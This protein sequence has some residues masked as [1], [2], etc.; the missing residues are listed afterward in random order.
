MSELLYHGPCDDCGSSDACATYDD[1]HSYCFS[2]GSH[3]QGDAAMPEHIQ[4]HTKRKSL[5]IITPCVP[6]AS[7]NSRNL[8]PETVRRF[9]VGY[10]IDKE[11]PPSLVFPYFDE[12]GNLVAQKLRDQDKNFSTRGNLKQA[13]L[14]GAHLCG[15]GGRLVVVTEGELDAMAVDQ[16]M[17]SPNGRRYGAVSI[18]NGAQGAKKSIT[19][20]LDWLCS[21]ETVVLCFDMDEPGRAA[22]ED[23]VGLFPPGKAAVAQ[24]PLKDACEMVMAHRESELSSAIWNATPHVPGGIV[25]LADIVD[26]VR[27]A[28]VRGI[29]WCIPEIDDKLYGR[30]YG[31][32]VG[33]GA[34]TGVGKTTLMTQQIAM[35]L[36]NG[37]SVGVFA[38]EQSP[39]ETLKRV[40]GQQSHKTFHV[41]GANWTQ[42]QLDEAIERL[43][44]SEHQLYLYD[45]FGV[46]DWE[47]IRERIRYLNKAHGVRIFFLDHLTALA[48][49]DPENE[50]TALERIMA[51]IGGIVKELDIWLMFVSHLTTPDKGA[52]EEGA[53]V[54][55][56]HFKGS[57]MI[58]AWA[59]FLLALERD[60]QA[61]TDED[62][63]LTTLRVL[64]D[65]FTGQ[66]LGVTVTLS[67]DQETGRLEPANPFVTDDVSNGAF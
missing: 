54:A 2:C 18:K 12:S 56:R 26:K 63:R 4:N 27:E 11:I 58:G 34:G 64:K 46:S 45:H 65:R 9:G 41:P 53:R 30:R 42:E 55:I 32:C 49:A 36:T 51:E 13:R 1:G 52:H 44:A 7:L 47:T 5:P 39:Q 22:V 61:E 17:T 23:C 35:D 62:R 66:G 50:R 37:H 28:P 6:T 31:E 29:P 43:Q 25:T 33:I 48:A 59:T 16:A 57:R 20:N 10:H 60:Q 15:S 40:L 67:Y 14:F 38:L 19:E 24:L 3:R 8:T 21:F